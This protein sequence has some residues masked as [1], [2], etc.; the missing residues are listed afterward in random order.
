MIEM[1]PLSADVE[2]EPV[3]PSEETGGPKMDFLLS[4]L[5]GALVAGVAVATVGSVASLIAGAF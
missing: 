3:F 1:V 2:A 5:V 4:F